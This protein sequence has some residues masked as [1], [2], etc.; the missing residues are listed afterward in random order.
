MGPDVGMT[1]GSPEGRPIRSKILLMLA[2][3]D[4]VLSK[5]KLPE[6]DWLLWQPWQLLVIMPW[7]SLA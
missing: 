4:A 1:R 5:F 6:A 7:I 3:R 2:V